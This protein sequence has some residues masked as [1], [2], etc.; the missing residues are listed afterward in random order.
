[1]IKV[2]EIFCSLQGESTKIG[3]LCV[4]VR[5]AG[6]NLNCKWCDT[7][8]ASNSV[9]ANEML[10]TEIIDCVKKYDC[11]FVEITGGEPLIQSE[12]KELANKLV[13]LGYEVAIETNGSVLLAGLDKEIIK[14]MDIKCPASG[15]AKNNLYENINYLNKR[16]EIKFVIAS[17][18]DFYWSIDVIKRYNLDEKVDNI[19]FSAVASAI[20][21]SD[22]AELILSVKDAKIREVIRMQLQLHKIIWGNEKGR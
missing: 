22:L 7:E 14:I 17:K 5:L 19:L 21:Y 2:S 12:T 6:C 20:R 13:K 11:N 4:F 1:M 16:D 3:K 9:N 8:Y 18:D 10:A 15:M